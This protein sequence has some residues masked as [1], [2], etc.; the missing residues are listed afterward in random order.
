MRKHEIKPGVVYAYQSSRGDWDRPTPIVFLTAPAD[1]I[2]FREA[3]PYGTR[4][5]LEYGRAHGAAKPERGRG[6]DGSRDTGYPAV[7]VDYYAIVDLEDLL[8]VTLAEFEQ[9]TSNYD[10]GVEGARFTLVTS[11]TH[12][13]GPY[14]E[15]RSRWMMRRNC[16][17]H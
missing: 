1:G 13:T 14:D 4:G 17:R 11:L 3:D 7:T 2:L 8:K 9:T 5:K 10:T 12:I 16:W 6:G 15:V